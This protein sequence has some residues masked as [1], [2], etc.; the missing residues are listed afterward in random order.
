MQAPC[1]EKGKK[2]KKKKKHVVKKGF[3]S[4][5]GLS[6]VQ[7]EHFINKF[8]VCG[9]EVRISIYNG[10]YFCKFGPFNVRHKAQAQYS[11]SY[12]TQHYRYV[13]TH[14]FEVKKANIY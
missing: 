1:L 11:I 5:N 13:E 12:I 2:K 10:T 3:N 4:S 7:S 14:R 6:R 8:R 9:S